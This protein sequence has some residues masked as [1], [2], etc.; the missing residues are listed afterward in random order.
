MPV[1]SS[2]VIWGAYHKQTTVTDTKK[3]KSGS[4]NPGAKNIK[5]LVQDNLIIYT[6]N[7]IE[8]NFDYVPL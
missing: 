7:M 5:R 2:S 4:Y 1:D 6:K 8:A 3:K